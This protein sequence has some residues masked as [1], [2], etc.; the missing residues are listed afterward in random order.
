M[1][2]KFK[3]GLLSQRR[4]GSR[5]CTFAHNPHLPT[6]LSNIVYVHTACIDRTDQL[7]KPDCIYNLQ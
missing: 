7:L 2:Q 5:K 3:S 4:L 1:K 6:S